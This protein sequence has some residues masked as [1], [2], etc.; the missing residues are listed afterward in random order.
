[1]VGNLGTDL[2][3]FLICALL[4]AINS[5]SCVSACS[6]S[7]MSFLIDSTEGESNFMAKPVAV[8][9]VILSI[10][11]PSLRFAAVT[12]QWECIKSFLLTQRSSSI[13]LRRFL[14]LVRAF[15][16]CILYRNRE[17]NRVMSAE[18]CSPATMRSINPWSVTTIQTPIASFTALSNSDHS[19]TNRPSA[20]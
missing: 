9:L 18:N 13:V 19:M 7:F 20:A 8:R 10:L 5:C 17:L 11:V 15:S 3:C 4:S 6:V 1:M 12:A 16:S 2:A 14:N